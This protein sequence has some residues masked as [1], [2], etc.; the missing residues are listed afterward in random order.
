MRHE[1]SDFRLQTSDFRLKLESINLDQN[2]MSSVLSLVS[3]K[4][5]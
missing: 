2:L 4:N 3:N 5:L 1:T